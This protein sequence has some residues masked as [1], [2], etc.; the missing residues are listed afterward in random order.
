MQ[1]E[2]GDLVEGGRCAHCDKYDILD[3]LI[4]EFRATLPHPLA[5]GCVQAR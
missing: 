1:S 2:E 4:I 3:H 5:P